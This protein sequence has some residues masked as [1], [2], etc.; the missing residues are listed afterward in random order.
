MTTQI[1]APYNF[2]PLSSW[3][4]QPSWAS[5][6]SHDLPFSD[7]LS[8]VLSIQLH[9]RTPLLVGQQDEREKGKVGKVQFCRHNGHYVIPGSSIK[10][11]LRNVMEIATFGKMQMVDEKRLGIR[12][13]SGKYVKEIYRENIKNQRAG[14]LCLKKGDSGLIKAEIRPCKYLHVCH[15]DLQKYIN[16][17]GCLFRQGLSVRQKYEYWRKLTG[18]SSESSA[19]DY[20]P[21]I[22]FEKRPGNSSRQHSVDLAIPTASGTYTGHLVFT[23]QITDKCVKSDG[24]SFNRKGKYRDF[25]F[26]DEDE[27]AIPVHS[28]VLADFRLIHGEEEK[29]QGRN[30]KQPER[31]WSGFWR[32]RFIES[33]EIPIFFRT[34]GKEVKS[35]G[36]A[37]MYKLAYHHTIAETI[38]HSNPLH[39]PIVLQNNKLTSENRHDLAELIFGTVVEQPPEQDDAKETDRTPYY[40]SLKSRVSVGLF[41]GPSVVS[42]KP[43]KPITTILAAPKPT[44]FP[45]YIR[46]QNVRNNKLA[47]PQ[48]Q[49]TTYMDED[50][51][52][53]GWKRYPTKQDSQVQQSDSLDQANPEAKI[54]LYPLPETSGPFTGTIRFHNLKAEELGALLWCITW[55]NKPEY[56]HSIGMGKPFGFGQVSLSIAKAEIFSNTVAKELEEDDIKRKLKDSISQFESFMDKEYSIATGFKILRW[57]ESP[58][59]RNLLAM[60]NPRDGWSQEKLQYMRL[61]VTRPR[62][63]EFVDAKQN[64]LVLPDY[65]EFDN[66]DF[67]EENLSTLRKRHQNRLQ[68]QEEKMKVAE[69]EEK[70]AQLS[71]LKRSIQK[72]VDEAQEPSHIAMVK[73]LESSEWTDPQDV[74]A[75][76][77]QVKEFLKE[78][79][80]WREKSFKKNPGKDKAF[81]LTLRTK[82]FLE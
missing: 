54:A 45:N 71:P 13:I 15:G 79:K 70:L 75:V 42:T 46:Q 6:V 49:Y 25:I 3:I 19:H 10:G 5:E 8:G 12:D 33:A 62:I 55:G 59:T 65:L 36:L 17:T 27:Q 51:K 37:F 78:R 60:A 47:G 81:Q 34:D 39:S 1:T 50:S 73:A 21:L 63:N 30:E 66:V 61:T 74:K 44:Y 72:V 28:K 35:I 16:H 22:D 48:T 68:E 80:L 56:R 57:S 2:V 4:L 41:L 69:K 52:I 58:Q 31:P 20:L 26:Y 11:M 29:E 38:A 64:G 9:A 67:S 43:L 14:Y 7:G 32:K 77:E 53:R 76:A 18:D 24:K 40:F 82:K 23:G